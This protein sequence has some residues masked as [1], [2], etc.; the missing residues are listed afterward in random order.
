MQY[1]FYVLYAELLTAVSSY[2]SA[3]LSAPGRWESREVAV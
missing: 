3:Q 1:T 2:N